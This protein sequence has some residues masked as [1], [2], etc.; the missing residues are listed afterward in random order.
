MTQKFKK[1]RNL[2]TCQ[3]ATQISWSPWSPKVVDFWFSLM[4][5]NSWKLFEKPMGIPEISSFLQRIMSTPRNPAC[6]GRFN[7]FPKKWMR[8]A[9][10]T[11]VLSIWWIQKKTTLQVNS[12]YLSFTTEL[13]SL[14]WLYIRNSYKLL[15]SRPSI[16]LGYPGPSLQFLRSK[17][18]SQHQPPE[19]TRCHE[20][21]W[22]SMTA[23]V[24][25]ARAHPWRQIN[26]CCM[27]GKYCEN[28]LFWVKLETINYKCYIHIFCSSL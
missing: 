5:L 15:S 19:P 18:C 10:E 4:K 14:S 11:K 17:N 21:C 8:T 23:V 24:L 16:K 28:H 13:F 12:K 22:V 3:K 25:V 9:H 26:L 7:M 6:C 1:E 20:C 27:A 2:Q